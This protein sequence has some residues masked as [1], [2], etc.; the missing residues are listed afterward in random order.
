MTWNDTQASPTEQMTWNDTHAS[1]SEQMTCN[2]AQ[3]SPTEEMTCNDTQASL[4]EQTTC[5]QRIV[6]GIEKLQRGYKFSLVI[7]SHPFVRIEFVNN[8]TNSVSF[9]KVH[10]K[11]YIVKMFLFRNRSRNLLLYSTLVHLQWHDAIDEWY[12][13]LIQF[14]MIRK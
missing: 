14:V 7:W 11:K 6:T 13:L 3:P 10:I 9:E 1:P 5:N 8:G 12:R 4:T 2:E